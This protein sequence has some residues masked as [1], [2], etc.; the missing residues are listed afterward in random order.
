MICR[1]FVR[2]AARWRV[3]D[4]MEGDDSRGRVNVAAIEF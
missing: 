3:C 4:S 1:G 2:Y